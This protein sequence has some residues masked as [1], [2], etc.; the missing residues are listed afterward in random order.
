[1]QLGICLAREAG[2]GE[3]QVDNGQCSREKEVKDLLWAG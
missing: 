1:M 3:P 2:E